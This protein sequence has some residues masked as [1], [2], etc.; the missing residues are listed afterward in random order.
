[1][2]KTSKSRVVLVEDTYSEAELYTDFLRREPVEVTHVSNGRD[3]IET[4][5]EMVPDLVLLDLQLP[6]ITGLDVLRDL[7]E[8]GV[9]VTAVVVTAHGSINTAV[10][11]MQAGA[12]D[13]V[14]KPST[15][16]GSRSRSGT[17]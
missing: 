9:P 17:R 8:R 10:E 1:M 3:A 6:D 16:T 7:R 5:T 2:T 15:R 11:A 14:V 12:I 13:F 4:I